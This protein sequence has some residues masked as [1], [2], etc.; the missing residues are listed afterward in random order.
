MFLYKYKEWGIDS[1]RISRK[2]TKNKGKLSY[3]QIEK[4]GTLCQLEQS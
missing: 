2:V 3:T 1:I 4:G